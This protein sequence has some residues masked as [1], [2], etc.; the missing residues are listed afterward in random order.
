VTDGV[1][2]GEDVEQAVVD[3]VAVMTGDSLVTDEPVT[4]AV[5]DALAL[6][7]AFGESD[8]EG[9]F[10]AVLIGDDVTDGVTVEDNVPK[11][12]KESIAD[13]E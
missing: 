12:V 10:V 6:S 11:D 8:C 9:E 5:L 7:V 13:A 3:D 4:E 1:I 2:D